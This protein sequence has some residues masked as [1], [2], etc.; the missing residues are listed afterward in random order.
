MTQ[1]SERSEGG[2]D[3]W[4][5]YIGRDYAEASAELDRRRVCTYQQ[6]IEE[7]KQIDWSLKSGE[8][9]QEMKLAT[10]KLLQVKTNDEYQIDFKKK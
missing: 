2:Y 4:G 9:L 7:V 5:N 8:T 1:I 3:G 10:D 6:A